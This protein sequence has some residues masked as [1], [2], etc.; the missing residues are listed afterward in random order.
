MKKGSKTR[1][2]ENPIQANAQ[3]KDTVFTTF[4]ADPQRLIRITNSLA[5]TQ[6]PPT[7][8]VVI[9]TLDTVLYRGRKND[10]SFIIN[11]QLFVFSEHQSTINENMPVRMFIYSGLLYEKLLNNNRELYRK[12]RITLPKPVFFVLYNGPE[13]FPAR[14]ELRLSDAFA[15]TDTAIENQ[16]ELVVTVININAEQN[17]PILKEN[18]DLWEYASFMERIH[19]NRK[20]M[21][22]DDAIHKAVVDC[23]RDGIM[24]DYLK[25]H[26]T[27]VVNMLM[28]E[29]KLEDEIKIT[30]EEAREEGVEE[31]L[32][33]GL[34]I[35]REEAREEK[36]KTARRLKAFGLSLDDIAAMTLLPLERLERELNQPSN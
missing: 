21:N 8:N 4:F 1:N 11:N 29:Y 14:K 36:L 28:E 15:P 3:Y 22:L 2:P 17:A 26:G 23:I 30:R 35:G 16:L 9:N 34:E 6:Y 31:G 10:I 24:V 33:K 18:H 27:E 13:P 19:T 12:K 32:E 7:A 25:E 5:K 20:T